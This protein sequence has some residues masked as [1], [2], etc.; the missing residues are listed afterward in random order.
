MYTLLHG[1]LLAEAKLKMGNS[2]CTYINKK[3]M[4][5]LTALGEQLKNG[6]NIDMTYQKM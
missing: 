2:K 1:P 6:L 4:K 3:T 5:T